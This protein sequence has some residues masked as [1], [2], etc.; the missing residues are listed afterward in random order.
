MLTWKV[1]EEE[2]EEMATDFMGLFTPN[3]TVDWRVVGEKDKRS[4]VD[5]NTEWLFFFPS[6]THM[7]SKMSV[8]NFQV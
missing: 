7:H 4:E 1:E 2:E 5:K 6:K 8:T 3:A